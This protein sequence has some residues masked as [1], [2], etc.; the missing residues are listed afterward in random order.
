MT[1]LKPPG[2]LVIYL[3][4]TAFFGLSCT[5]KDH[6]A[7]DPAQA[8]AHA[9]EDYDDENYDIALQKLGE[10]KSRFPYSK[11]AA[12]AELFIANCH[13]ELGNYEEAAVEYK[14]F[15]KLHPRHEKVPFALYRAGDSYWV[16]APEEVDRDQEYTLKALDEW[17]KLVQQFPENKYSADAKKLIRQGKRRIAA[18][19]E[20]IADFYCKME[21]YHACAFRFIMLIEEFPEY[22]DLKNKALEKG[23]M[24]L[25]ET[26]R[27]KREDPK[28]D[29]NLYFRS[30]TAQQ[31]EQKARNMRKLLP[32]GYS[33]G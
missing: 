27:I 26:A 2:L 3:V 31:I 22:T 13:Y 30:M 25:E 11:F 5:E 16:D 24:A 6:D 21:I 9:R 14:Q 4:F 23:A 28:S 10:F 15:A 20:F 12:L 7:N 18:S 29:K 33:E 17:K 1:I 8:F 19:Y 32:P